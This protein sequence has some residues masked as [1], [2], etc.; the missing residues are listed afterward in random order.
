MLCWVDCR[1]SEQAEE[2]ATLVTDAA[3]TVGLTDEANASSSAAA[4]AGEDAGQVESVPTN[5]HLIG[6]PTC[7]MHCFTSS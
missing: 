1:V 5:V 7:G 4:T 2:D 3:Q 6:Q